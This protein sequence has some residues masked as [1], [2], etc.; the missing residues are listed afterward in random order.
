AEPMESRYAYRREK[1]GSDD[2]VE[3][4]RARLGFTADPIQELAL[5]GGRRGIVNCTR[6][7][8]KSTVMAVKAVHRAMQEARS[9]TLTLSPS[10]RQSGEVMR[11]AGEV[12]RT[13]GIRARGAGGDEMS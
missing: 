6:Q 5:R 3:W 1:A 2:P 10:A 8:G 4:A 7:W 12:V 13:L 11:K 9:L